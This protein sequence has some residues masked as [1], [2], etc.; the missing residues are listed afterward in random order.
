MTNFP[1][2]INETTTYPG[3]S[4]NH[5]SQQET[6][7]VRVRPN[8][9]SPTTRDLLTWTRF[10]VPSTTSIKTKPSSC[11]GRS[12]SLMELH[13]INPRRSTTPIVCEP[14]REVCSRRPGTCAS[15]WGSVLLNSRTLRAA[16]RV[17]RKETWANGKD[18]KSKVCI[19]A[20]EDNMLLRIC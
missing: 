8:L 11:Q 2:P 20:P 6:G 19:L 4:H 1:G 15:T 7:G 18:G 10:S 14:M 17:H 13:Q 3:F 5:H 9:T 12:S 16:A